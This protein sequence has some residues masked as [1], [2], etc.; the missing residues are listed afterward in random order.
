MSG[1]RDRTCIQ[2][3]GFMDKSVNFCCTGLVLILAVR[4]LPEVCLPHGTGEPS[5]N[6]QLVN[7]PRLPP[8]SEFTAGCELRDGD[9]EIRPY[10]HT[11]TS[12][13]MTLLSNRQRTFL[14][15]AT[16]TELIM[17]SYS[18]SFSEVTC[19]SSQAA[20]RNPKP[21]LLSCRN[22]HGEFETKRNKAPSSSD[23]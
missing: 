21:G 4:W 8:I 11:T 2:T 17:S 9:A 16:S 14:S 18:F 1:L 23:Q 20:E 7:S 22:I 6:A 5:S 12:D 15:E 13:S 10:L 3:C 19:I